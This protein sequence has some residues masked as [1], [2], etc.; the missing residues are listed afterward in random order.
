MKYPKGF[1][2][3][4]KDLL[5]VHYLSFLLPTVRRLKSIGEIKKITYI[6]KL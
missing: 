1:E 4:F 3:F 6:S 2:E 5:Y